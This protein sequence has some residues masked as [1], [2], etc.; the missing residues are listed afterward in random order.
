MEDYAI[1]N[2]L[3][4][5]RNRLLAALP[6][7]DRRKIFPELELVP[8]P[9]GKVLYDA[10][11]ALKHAYFPVSSMVSTVYVM[12]NGAS[13]E[14]AATGRDGMVGL[15]LFMGGRKAQ[16]RAV[17]T[18]GGYAYRLAEDRISKDS[19][20][21]SR[22]QE[23]LLRYAQAL[24]TQMAQI[25]VC[26]RHHSL[27][28]QLCRWLL[29]S[30]E[31]F[32]SSIIPITHETISNMLGVRREGVTVAAGRLQSVG[33]ISYKR[34]R[35]VVL[36]TRLLQAQACECHRTIRQEFNRLLPLPEEQAVVLHDTGITLKQYA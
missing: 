34:G 32:P 4:P 16:N 24:L 8:L 13:T 29:M 14:V 15:P 11:D 26:N 20:H 2:I 17:A 25:A 5:E 6:E 18:L 7:Y 3:W 22:L 33:A 35:I 30:L 12:E 23:I 27:E 19:V 9:T 1:A 28:Q 36:D 21:S 31:R 10:G